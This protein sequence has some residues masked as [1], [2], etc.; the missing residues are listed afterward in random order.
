MLV[1]AQP[2]KTTF[3]TFIMDLPCIAQCKP[4]RLRTGALR[5]TSERL[6]AD[7]HLNHWLKVLYG[8]ASA[9][10]F[11]GGNIP[12]GKRETSEKQDQA[13]DSYGLKKDFAG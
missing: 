1:D 3:I 6:A 2:G 11:R 10:K 4:G 7:S 8:T 9:G 12:M 13:I 5:K